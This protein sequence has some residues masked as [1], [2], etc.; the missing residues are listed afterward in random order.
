MIV[1]PSTTGGDR[2]DRSADRI[3]LLVDVVHDVT[4]FESLV[5]VLDTDR[6]ESRGN[7]LL[8]P[9]LVRFGRHQ[10]TGNLFFHKLIVRLVLVEGIDHVVAIAPG[11]P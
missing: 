4:D 3:D 1:A 5:H 8:I 6:Q 9:L 7:Q 11:M 10:I 2:Q